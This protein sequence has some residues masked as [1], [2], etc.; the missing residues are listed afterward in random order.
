MPAM[1]PPLILNAKLHERK[2]KTKIPLPFLPLYVFAFEGSSPSRAWPA[3]TARK[4]AEYSAKE[5]LAEYQPLASIGIHWRTSSHR[6]LV[7]IAEATQRALIIGPALA[8]LDP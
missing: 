5:I 1:D 3:P 8:H 6:L 2:E 7:P 4:G